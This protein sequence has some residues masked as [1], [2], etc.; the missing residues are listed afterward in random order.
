MVARR[1]SRRQAVPAVEVVHC[2]RDRRGWT[3]TP[4]GDSDDNGAVPAIPPRNRT[5]LWKARMSVSQIPAEA[6][7]PYGL[8]TEA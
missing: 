1:D 2:Q 3:P 7:D 6:G 5:V 8:F 4:L